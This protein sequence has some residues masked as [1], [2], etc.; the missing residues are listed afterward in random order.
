MNSY[1]FCDRFDWGNKNRE[2]WKRER[3]RINLAR[4]HHSY[5]YPEFK[6]IKICKFWKSSQ[7]A[8]RSV[9]SEKFTFREF[10]WV[11]GVSLCLFIDPFR[12]SISLSLSLY[13]YIYILYAVWTSDNK[14]LLIVKGEFFL[15]LCRQHPGIFVA[16]D[17][18]D[19]QKRFQMDCVIPCLWI[20]QTQRGHRQNR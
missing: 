14:W 1:L 4:W 19:R 16:T 12:F 6:Y 10:C 17:H 9:V 8:S 20:F 3:W 18:P 2:F 7:L 5:Q 11:G 13:I 15:F